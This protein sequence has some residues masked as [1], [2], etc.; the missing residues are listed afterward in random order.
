MWLTRLWWC[1]PYIKLFSAFL[2]VP[3]CNFIWQLN[4][5]I[6]IP[7]THD[8]PLTILKRHFRFFK[9]YLFQLETIALLINIVVASATL[10]HESAT[11]AHVSCIQDH[12]Y[13][14]SKLYIYILYWCFSFWTTS[15]YKI[16][17]SFIH[18]IRNDSNAFLFIAE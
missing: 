15:L 10:Q 11:G 13:S 4:L 18:F 2:P 5:V 9:N 17:S 3:I 8:I 16:G 14:L 7:F 6:C 12:Y 1:N